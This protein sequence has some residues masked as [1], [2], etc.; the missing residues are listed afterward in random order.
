MNTMRDG[1]DT[2]K[3]GNGQEYDTF[4]DLRKEM[5]TTFVLILLGT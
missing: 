1:L 4:G 5:R 2:L 3:N